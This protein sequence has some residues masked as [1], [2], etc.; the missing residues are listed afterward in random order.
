MG[1]KGEKPVRGYV[2]YLAQAVVKKQ[3]QLY[4]AEYAITLIT[5]RWEYTRLNLLKNIKQIEN[6]LKKAKKRE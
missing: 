2:W 6:E 4:E 3:I 1:K 5:H